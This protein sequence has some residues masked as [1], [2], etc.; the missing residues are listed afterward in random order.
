MLYLIIGIIITLSFAY[1]LNRNEEK[2]DE[3]TEFMYISPMAYIVV[4][5]IVLLFS[6]FTYLIMGLLLPIDDAEYTKLKSIDYEVKEYEDKEYYLKTDEDL[7]PNIKVMYL[8][9]GYLEEEEFDEDIVKI[10]LTDEVGKKA[11]ITIS[12]EKKKEPSTFEKVFLLK[13]VFG[14]DEKVSSV[15]LTLPKDARVTK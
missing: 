12:K 8:K 13:G 14:S 10:R 6:F 9:D 11:K 1:L 7:F 2:N 3:D 4:L 15:V 5:I